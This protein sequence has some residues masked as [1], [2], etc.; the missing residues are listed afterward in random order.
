MKVVH[1]DI[2]AG[3]TSTVCNINNDDNPG[4]CVLLFSKWL[5]FGR[6]LLAIVQKGTTLDGSIFPS[7][8]LSL[9]TLACVI[10]RT[11]N[12]LSLH[13]CVPPLLNI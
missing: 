6:R 11:S 12:V 5:F 4:Y 8:Y 7:V 2:S 10:S 9:K 13:V 1:V 3:V